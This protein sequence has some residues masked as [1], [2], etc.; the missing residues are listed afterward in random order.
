MSDSKEVRNWE[1]ATGMDTVSSYRGYLQK[2]P[3][4]E[5]QREARR[6]IVRKRLRIA[7]F[8]VSFIAALALVVALAFAALRGV[9]N[10]MS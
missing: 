2:N 10:S 5:H 6:R 1:F 8:V 4:G 9:A 3:R 7:L